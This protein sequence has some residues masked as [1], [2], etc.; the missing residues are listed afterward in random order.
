MAPSRLLVGSVAMEPVSRACQ[1]HR[2]CCCVAI[3]P[4]NPPIAG[5]EGCGGHLV[6]TLASR[7]VLSALALSEVGLTVLSPDPYEKMLDLSV[8]LGVCLRRA[9]LDTCTTGRASES[10][11]QMPRW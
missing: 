11:V 4:A 9:S 8:A 3:P 10:A 6:P 2:H 7:G 1:G 5:L